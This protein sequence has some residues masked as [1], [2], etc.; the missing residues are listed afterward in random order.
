MT[1]GELPSSVVDA[2]ALAA[3]VVAILAAFAALSKT[4]PARYLWRWLVS[5]PIGKWQ[6]ATIEAALAPMQATAEADRKVV[7]DHMHEELE[8][9]Q[10]DALDREHRQAELDTFRDDMRT[11]VGVMNRNFVGLHRRL[12]RTLEA[13][14]AGKPVQISSVAYHDDEE[15]HHG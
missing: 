15:E 11:E 14:A 7:T 2:G 5:E 3:V 8:L 13:I 6:T 10:A 4:P 9:R 12:D 1:L